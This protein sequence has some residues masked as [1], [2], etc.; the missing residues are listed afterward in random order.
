[1]AFFPPAAEAKSSNINCMGTTDN[2]D[3]LTYLCVH[4]CGSVKLSVL[5]SSGESA[6]RKPPLHYRTRAELSRRLHPSWVKEWAGPIWSRLFE[7]GI[8][9]G[10][11]AEVRVEAG[12]H[13]W[14]ALGVKI[15]SAAPD[16]G[17]PNPSSR[18][19]P[20][21]ARMT[22]TVTGKPDSSPLQNVQDRMGEYIRTAST[23]WHLHTHTQRVH[24]AP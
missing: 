1:M 6:H 5:V 19:R 18:L 10:P 4:I 2:D 24:P 11:R 3:Y 20:F 14:T 8:K 12:G 15:L 21:D 23:P 22:R 9:T 13:S 17:V 7:I 16:F